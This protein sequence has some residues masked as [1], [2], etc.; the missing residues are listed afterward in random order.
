MIKNVRKERKLTVMRSMSRLVLTTLGLVLLF[1]G[2]FNLNRS[3]ANA[4][5]GG[6]CRD[7]CGCGDAGPWLCCTFQ[8]PD[9]TQISCYCNNLCG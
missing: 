2:S 8:Y 7:T 6:F 4:P 9:G 3:S 5:A 1:A